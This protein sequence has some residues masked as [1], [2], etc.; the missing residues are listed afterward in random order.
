VVYANG[1]ICIYREQSEEET[2]AV[3][4]EIKWLR[5]NPA[6]AS[7]PKLSGLCFLPNGS[8][9]AY[10]KDKTISLFEEKRMGGIACA[11]CNIF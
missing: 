10:D 9:V 3:I 1:S 6:D 4:E 5:K 2:D 8:F 7:P 11:C